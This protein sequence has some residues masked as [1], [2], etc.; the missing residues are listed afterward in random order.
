MSHKSLLEEL[1]TYV[2]QSQDVFLKNTGTNVMSSMMNLLEYLDN[3]FEKE[4]V[5]IVVS[6]IVL[7]IRTRNIKKFENLIERGISNEKNK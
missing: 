6:K 3:N 7:S 5:D 2:P 4:D 1:I